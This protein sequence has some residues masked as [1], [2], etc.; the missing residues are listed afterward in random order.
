MNYQAI[1]DNEPKT[2]TSWAAVVIFMIERI[3]REIALLR[4]KLALIN[5]MK[6][7]L[8]QEIPAAVQRRQVVV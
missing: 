5:L 7:K 4:L 6:L 8:R 1:L 3:E 2:R